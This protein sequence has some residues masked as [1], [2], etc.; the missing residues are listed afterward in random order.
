MTIAG[1]D[2]LRHYDRTVLGRDI[3]GGV[4]AGAVVI[5]QS[6]AYATI[7]HLPVQVGL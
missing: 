1:V 2:W 5:P 7:A 4:T 3:L 6:M